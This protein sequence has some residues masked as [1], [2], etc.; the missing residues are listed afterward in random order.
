MRRGCETP[1][2]M[3]AKHGLCRRRTALDGSC[4]FRAVAEQVLSTQSKHLR[5]RE[6]CVN[7]L[8]EN[9]ESFQAFIE[10]P[11]E[12]YL[13]RLSNPKEWAGHVEMSALSLIYRRDFVI[14]REIDLPPTNV[15][16]HGFPKKINLLFSQ[17]NHYDNVYTKSFQEFSA[18]CQSLIYEMLY[19]SVFKIPMEELTSAVELFRT[20]VRKNKVKESSVLTFDET[21]NEVLSKTEWGSGD[22]ETCSQDKFKVKLEK[23]K[24]H[25]E[26][27]PRMPFP[28][29][30]LKSLDSEI[31]RNVEYDVWLED[32]KVADRQ[33]LDPQ[34]A[35]AYQYR[36]GDKCQVRVEVGG[37]YYNAHVQE[38]TS[39]EGPVTVFIEELA[40][41]HQVE[42]KDLKPMSQVTPLPT[43]NFPRRKTSYYAKYPG[44]YCRT[45]ELD[46]TFRKRVFHQGHSREAVSPVSLSRGS[47]VQPHRLQSDG[48]YPT[49]GG[50][51]QSTPQVS[52]NHFGFHLHRSNAP[53]RRGTGRSCARFP[54]RQQVV[55]P[56]GPGFSAWRE[57][58]P[59]NAYGSHHRGSRRSEFSGNG[60]PSG[61]EG[62][63]LD[64]EQQ[65]D[66]GV[67]YVDNFGT[68]KDDG[69]YHMTAGIT[70]EAGFWVQE[71]VN[72][73]LGEIKVHDIDLGEAGHDA[74]CYQFIPALP[75]ADSMVVNNSMSDIGVTLK[76]A[77]VVSQIPNPQV[78]SSGIYPA[79]FSGTLSPMPSAAT[80]IACPQQAVYTTPR[81][82]VVPM[83][84]PQSPQ[85]VS[86]GSA[87]PQ[88]SPL[89]P[90]CPQNENGEVIPQFSSEPNCGDL[91]QDKKLVQYF[92]NLGVQF[93]HQSH[94]QP[95]GFVPQ[96]LPASEGYHF[97]LSTLIEG[98]AQTAA[99]MEADKVDVEEDLSES[100]TGVYASPEICSMV[101]PVQGMVQGGTVFYPIPLEPYAISPTTSQPFDQS[102]AAHPPQYIGAWSQNA[103]PTAMQS[104]KQLSTYPFGPAT[105]YASPTPSPMTGSCY[106]PGVAPQFA[107]NL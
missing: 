97:Q 44:Q 30:V 11:F 72:N 52:P 39:E 9:R 12:K 101:A 28:F 1:D 87:I 45:S 8:R 78:E 107:K 15:T 60:S 67:S 48:R 103:A 6:A 71:S 86:W 81:V 18:F 65:I 42:M 74:P 94:Y 90:I 100:G 40:E 31:Y 99:Y 85:G 89:G 77:P 13:Q 76:S 95:M 83:M 27:M 82:S 22:M 66:D 26:I 64:D 92:Y 70:H 54:F 32:Q 24:V 58:A 14:Y 105:Q 36:V 53:V 79:N 69:G 5:V 75:S 73:P 23:N 80:A 50:A 59:Y 63:V 88:V 84:L 7:F 17:G 49:R 91:P 104:P 56:N 37:Q 4:L 10:G 33:R 68:A 29:K 55:Y 41:K 3:L 43:W 35:G 47:L 102:Y 51:Q 19:H 93:Y 96:A 16:H 62:G 106:A 25:S 46:T 34:A 2:E 57:T 61:F 98:S 38:L 20:C 21:A